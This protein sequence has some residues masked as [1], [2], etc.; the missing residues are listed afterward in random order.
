MIKLKKILKQTE[1]EVSF[2]SL[3]VGRNLSFFFIFGFISFGVL[4]LKHVG[5]FRKE[6]DFFYFT[7][8]LTCSL[9]WEFAE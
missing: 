2:F 1:L 5:Y 4:F 9:L 8:L 7:F 3:V 6:L